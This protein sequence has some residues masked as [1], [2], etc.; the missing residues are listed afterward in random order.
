MDGSM[1]GILRMGA[2][3][4]CA[5]DENLFGVNDNLGVCHIIGH[6]G[7]LTGFNSL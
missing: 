6:G 2:T 1:V 3:Q 4:G 5:S 7:A